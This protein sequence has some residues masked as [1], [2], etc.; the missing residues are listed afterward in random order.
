MYKAKQ[1]PK[2][3][4]ENK[5]YKKMEREPSMMGTNKYEVGGDNL[6]GELKLESRRNARGRQTV[7]SSKI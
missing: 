3:R 7:K 2:G 5:E 4:K 1:R 6:E